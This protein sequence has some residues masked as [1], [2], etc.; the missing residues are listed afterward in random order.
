MG[1]LRLSAAGAAAGRGRQRRQAGG[2]RRQ[3]QPHDFGRRRTARPSRAWWTPGASRSPSVRWPVYQHAPEPPG[4]RPQPSRQQ[5]PRR[6]HAAC[7]SRRPGRRPPDTD[8]RGS[9]SFAIRLA[10]APP[11]GEASD[12]PDFSADRLGG[13]G[14]TR[15]ASIRTPSRS[16]DP[17]PPASPTVGSTRPPTTCTRPCPRP[18]E[19]TPHMREPC[20]SPRRRVA[21]TLIELLVVMALILVVTALGIGYVVFGQDNQHSVTAAQAVTGALLNA[22]RRAR[23]DGRPTG[24]RILFDPNTKLA[25]QLAIHPAARRLQLRPMQRRDQRDAADVQQRRF[26]GRRRLHRRDRRVHHPGRRLLHGQRFADAAHDYASSVH[27]GQQWQSH[28]PDVEPGLVRDAVGRPAVFH[29]PR[30]AAPAERRRHPAAFL[31]CHRRQPKRSA[32]TCRSG[33]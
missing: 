29:H 28:G 3:Q 19:E 12:L 26:P 15:S 2:P 14:Q 10:A 27:R 31:H 9:R 20:R 18:S 32:R 23:R 24:V 16:P 6:S 5:R 1:I 13:A 8:S 30:A 4:G 22:K 17:P 7:W 11:A 33:R 25:T 21:F